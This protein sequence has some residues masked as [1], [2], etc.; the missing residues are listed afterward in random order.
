LGLTRTAIVEGFCIHARVL[1]EFL[2]G[3]RGW[4]HGKKVANGYT[5][6]ENGEIEPSII[7]MLSDHVAH[8]TLE[9][10]TDTGKLVRTEI[11]SMLVIALAE[12][13]MVLRRRLQVGR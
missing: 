4:A 3:K 10:S 2:T 7:R 9:R 1:H 13:L 8:L 6:F 5:P 12:E 11:R